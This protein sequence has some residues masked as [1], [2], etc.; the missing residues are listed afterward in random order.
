MRLIKVVS[1]CLFAILC[2]ISH[3][4]ENKYI[5]VGQNGADECSQTVFILELVGDDP[6]NHVMINDNGEI[7]L[8]VDKIVAIPKETFTHIATSNEFIN[9]HAA[10]HSNIVYS[11][12]Q[13]FYAFAGDVIQCGS[14]A[15]KAPKKWQCPYC[16]YWWEA[17]ET[18]TND[19]CPTNQWKKNKE[20]E[21]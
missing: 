15:S 16:H 13:E 14:R 1:F 12:A 4:H 5:F 21:S 19:N 18:C 11:D 9:T 10:Q 17:G 6:G 7:Y 2:C 3:A 8:K 20:V